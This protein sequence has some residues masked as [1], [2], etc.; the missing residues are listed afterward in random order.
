MLGRAASTL[1]GAATITRSLALARGSSRHVSSTTRPTTSTTTTTTR[2]HSSIRPGGWA[3]GVLLAG[4]VGYYLGNKGDGPLTATRVAAGGQGGRGRGGGGGG[5]G[6]V[7]APRVPADPSEHEVPV[8][9]PVEVLDLAAANA[10]IREQASSFVFASDAEGGRGRVDVVRVSSNNPVEDEWAL[11]F[12]RGVG[13][14]GALYAGVYDG[15]AGW[16]TSAVLKDALIRYVSSSLGKLPASSDGPSV[17]AAIQ[18]A[19]VRLDDRIMAT[20]RRALNADYE[21]GAAAAIRA[22][23][24]AI[25]GSCA[26][27]CVYEPASRT[28]RTAVTGDSRAVLGSRTAGDGDYT[29]A[30]EAL[31]KD[32]TGFNA[33]E[34][35]RLEREHP[36]E[37]ADVIDPKT[38][39][40]LGI[41]V[42]RGFGDHRWKWSTEDVSSAQGRFYGFG[43]RQKVKTPPYMTARPEVTT[44]RVSADDF[45]ILASDGLWDVMSN[46]DAVACVRRWLA[47]KRRGR[48]EDVTPMESRLM[49]GAGG[50]GAWKATPDTFAVEDLDSAAVCLVKNALGGRRRALFCGAATAGA[51]QSRYVRDDMTVQVIFFKDPYA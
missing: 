31:S 27:L 12:G 50:Y 30:A 18:G 1:R 25:A 39:R 21:H 34:C 48:A 42:T 14:A 28:L 7:Q 23:A 44:R 11:G 10:K 8:E 4:G 5:G 2:L 9:S 36:G 13:G 38:G 29:Y 51:P 24:P 16:A 19:F 40:L 22:L 49:V 32:Q 6:Q 45:V 3:V 20:A 15:H 26:L 41:A 46:D 43:P 37:L 47:A 17:D 33:D 35:A